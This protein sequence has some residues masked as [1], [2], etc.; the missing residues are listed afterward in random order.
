MREYIFLY[1]LLKTIEWGMMDY[2][3]FHLPKILT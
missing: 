1:V 3:K 2:N